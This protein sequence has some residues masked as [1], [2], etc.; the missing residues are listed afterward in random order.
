MTKIK[1]IFTFSLFSDAAKSECD[2]NM[3]N[4]FVFAT[5]PIYH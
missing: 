4:M 1:D 3:H 2:N 5:P